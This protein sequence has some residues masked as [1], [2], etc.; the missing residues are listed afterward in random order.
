LGDAP[1]YSGS[2]L[3]PVFVVDGVTATGEVVP[4]TDYVVTTES[5]NAGAATATLT[6]NTKSNFTLGNGVKNIEY[7][8]A[9]KELIW[10]GEGAIVATLAQNDDDEAIELNHYTW[11]NA[12]IKPAVVLVDG[13]KTIPASNY[14][15]TYVN[16]GSDAYTTAAGEKYAV[17]KAKADAATI[18]AVESGV[19]YRMYRGSD[20]MKTNI[21]DAQ[22]PGLV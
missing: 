21:L 10:E 16:A 20:I 5:V 3:K 14:T 11:T 6:F 9:K 18:M 8:I 2:A 15:I 7:V 1:T 22:Q 17:V 13:T 4:E 12:D 19:E